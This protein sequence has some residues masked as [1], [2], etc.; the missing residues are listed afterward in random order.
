MSCEIRSPGAGKVLEL[1]V[2]VGAVVAEGDELVVLE[3]MKMEIPV[4][5]PQAGTVTAVHVDLGSQVQ[6]HAL[7]VTLC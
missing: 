4:V 6:E 5:A 1:P 2:V 7:L 3:S